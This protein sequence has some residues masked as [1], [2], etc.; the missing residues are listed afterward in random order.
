MRKLSVLGL[1]WF[2]INQLSCLTS[3]A[4]STGGTILDD[5]PSSY[6]FAGLSVNKDADGFYVYRVDEAS[7]AGKAGLKASDRLESFE[8]AE[9]GAIIKKTLR[10]TITYNP[11]RTITLTVRRGGQLLTL[12]LRVS[13][14]QEFP[15]DELL[16]D[17]REERKRDSQAVS[18]SDDLFSDVSEL[19][20]VV[21]FFDPQLGPSSILLDKRL[22]GLKV[23]CR[24]LDNVDVRET[25]KKLGLTQSPQVF[26]VDKEDEKLYPFPIGKNWR[27][28]RE[29]FSTLH[30]DRP[31]A[32]EFAAVS[33]T[34]GSLPEPSPT[35]AS[36]G[37]TLSQ[38]QFD[39]WPAIVHTGL[40]TIIFDGRGG[41]LGPSISPLVPLAHTWFYQNQRGYSCAEASKRK[42]ELQKL[43][44][45]IVRLLNTDSL[46]TK[47][48]TSVITG[49]A[50]FA[51]NSIKAGFEE[52]PGLG[53]FGQLKAS[54][55]DLRLVSPNCAV[56]RVAHANSLGESYFYLIDDQGWRL[57]AIR[58]PLEGK[59]AAP[60]H[61]VEEP[62]IDENWNRREA[63]RVKELTASQKATYDSHK[64]LE[65]RVQ[66][67]SLMTD[68][69]VRQWFKSRLNALQEIADQSMQS[70]RTGDFVFSWHTK[71]KKPLLVKEDPKASILEKLAA[72][73]LDGVEKLKDKNV[74][75]RFGSARY[76][77]SGLLYSQ[78]NCPPPIGPYG[79]LWTE[80]LADHWYLM[81]VIDSHQF[82]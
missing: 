8:I 51:G 34:A 74:F 39:G 22:E 7:P 60:G 70:L 2:A 71:L 5:A 67:R 68:T 25:L 35:I 36:G 66:K 69:E 30:Y 29:M 10:K 1:A 82:E 62:S 46:D 13:S 9:P 58:T 11:N 56:A 27:V 21:E 26:T 6:G 47:V 49:E 40:G 3:F 17:K 28:N 57:S 61:D 31:E 77:P 50:K 65:L 14:M 52:N 37:I 63:A 73:E 76:S 20:Q 32:G 42:K 38:K 64:D 54:A 33:K 48:G 55:P 41:H 16:K 81:R 43:L 44:L 72:Q 75:L 53:K 23:M 24:A 45:Q 4:Q 79:T 80:K 12:L 19:P 18:Y 78:D 59:K 15:D